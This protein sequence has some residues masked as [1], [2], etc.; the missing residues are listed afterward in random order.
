MEGEIGK[1]KTCLVVSLGV[2]SKDGATT[3]NG[4]K[5][6]LLT[7]SKPIKGVLISA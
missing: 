3:D 7:F 1:V 4:V 2:L 6:A 5:G